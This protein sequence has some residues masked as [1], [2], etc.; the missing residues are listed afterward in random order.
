MSRTYQDLSHEYGISIPTLKKYKSIGINPEDA[1]A[2]KAQYAKN[3]G[4]LKGYRKKVQLPTTP[5]DTK[6]LVNQTTGLNAT[7]ERLEKLEPFLHAAYLKSISDGE[8]IDT[9]HSKR[10]A[11]ME[12]AEKVRITAT[13]NP[14]VS[15]KTKNLV[16]ATDVLKELSV[17]M[18]A[19]YIEGENL[20]NRVA[21]KCGLPDIKFI[22]DD[23][24][25]NMFKALYECKWIEGRGEESASG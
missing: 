17:A 16:S 24:I 22:V 18:K 9:Q 20:G 8:P 13:T 25:K 2:V 3:K 1:E 11:W 23:E 10:K 14:D 15:E 4:S 7:L 21:L 12:M 19:F 5:L 6:D